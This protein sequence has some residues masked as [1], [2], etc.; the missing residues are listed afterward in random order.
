MSLSSPK[1]IKNLNEI[2]N[3]YDLF[4]V[5]L[6]GVIHNGVNLFSNAIDVLKKLQELKKK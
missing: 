5:D 6:W 3:N 4:F 1:E 2:I